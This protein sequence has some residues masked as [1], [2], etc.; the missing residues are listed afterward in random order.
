MKPDKKLNFYLK[1]AAQ[2]VE[3]AFISFYWRQDVVDVD[4][5][6]IRKTIKKDAKIA[7]IRLM[8]TGGCHSEDCLCCHYA[9]LEE[10][11]KRAPVYEQEDVLK[12]GMKI[13]LQYLDNL[14]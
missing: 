6:S 13:V 11:A 7:K 1:K 4:A 10:G 2:E 9:I 14:S 5:A 8:N 12:T 3:E